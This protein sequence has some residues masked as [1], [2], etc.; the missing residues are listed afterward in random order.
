MGEPHFFWGYLP[1]WLVTYLTAVIAWTCIGRF[2]LSF[3]VPPGSTNYIWRAFVWITQGPVA[4][5]RLITPLVVGPRPLW[6]ATAFWFF[7]LRYMA[8]LLFSAQGMTPPVSP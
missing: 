3:L 1:F 8:F 5:I 4:L 6:L 2:A 7:A